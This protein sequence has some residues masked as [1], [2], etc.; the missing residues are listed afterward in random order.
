MELD[1]DGFR[2]PPR[3]EPVPDDPDA[4]G[5]RSGR[6]VMLPAGEPFEGLR[7]GT[8]PPALP[9]SA[10]GR[11]KRRVVLGALA[12]LLV[13]T[14]GVPFLWPAVQEAVID[15]SLAGIDDAQARGDAAAALGHADRALD[16]GGDD[17]RLLCLRG[18]LRM[19][20]GD[21][22][23][24]RVDIDRACGLA[25]TAPQPLRLRALVNTILERPDEAL[26]DAQAVVDLSTPGDPESLNLRAYT[27][28]LLRR[29]LPEALADIEQALG[30]GGEQSPEHLDTRGFILHLL[31][32]NA[33]A[34]DDLNRAIDGMQASRKRLESL[35]GRVDGTELERR[36][37]S[38]DQS[39][40][41]MHHHRGEACAAA[42][43]ARQAQQ[44]LEV[45]ERKGYDP[46]RGIF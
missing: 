26:A 43:F 1:R 22:A 21:P 36:L 41:V 17:H 2:I 20:N 14:V 18:Q 23:G 24:A 42:G 12:A 27:R 25:P 32:R 28:A 34:I 35:R 8:R 37:R 5:P 31:G 4:F 46:A 6:A 45:A 11:A 15:W 3:F 10:P 39:L 30:R 40:A 16:W 19:E 13:G 33:E 7:S 9:R 44:D 29:D 38:I